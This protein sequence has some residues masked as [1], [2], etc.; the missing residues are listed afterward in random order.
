MSNLLETVLDDF[1]KSSGCGTVPIV[2]DHA[3]LRCADG[4]EVRL[5]CDSRRGTITMQSIV[6]ELSS[7]TGSSDMSAS[8]VRVD[9]AWTTLRSVGDDARHEALLWHPST[10]RV[11]ARC[12]APGRELDAVTFVSWVADF[13]DRLIQ[14]ESV[15]TPSTDTHPREKP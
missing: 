10:R 4:F 5:S 7:R 6:G 13:I 11:A 3:W 12:T 14:I 9:D 2:N 1:A 15:L 8:T